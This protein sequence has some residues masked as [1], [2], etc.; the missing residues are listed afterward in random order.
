MFRLSFQL[1]DGRS[2]N[3]FSEQRKI[4]NKNCKQTQWIKFWFYGG[5]LNFY[6]YLMHNILLLN[7]ICCHTTHSKS[8]QVFPVCLKQ[9]CS[10]KLKFDNSFF[11]ARQLSAISVSQLYFGFLHLHLVV[12]FLLHL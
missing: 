6:F 1:E 5:E 2:T 3:Y 7:I 8:I 10:C 9:S 11:V 4:N 12:R